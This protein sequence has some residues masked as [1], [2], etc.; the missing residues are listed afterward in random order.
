MQNTLFSLSSIMI[1]STG[2]VT[3]A[4]AI[5]WAEAALIISGGCG[6]NRATWHLPCRPMPSASPGNDIQHVTGIKFN[7]TGIKFLSS[8]HCEK[9]LQEKKPHRNNDFCKL[10]FSDSI[11]ISKEKNMCVCFIF[12]QVSLFISTLEFTNEE[13]SFLPLEMHLKASK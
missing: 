13:R 3:H 1:P 7:V 8:Y 10:Y 12:S 9:S 4:R 11:L 5:A 2:Q 6:P